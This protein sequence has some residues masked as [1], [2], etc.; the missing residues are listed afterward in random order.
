MEGVYTYNNGFF[1]L[2]SFF[3]SKGE[4]FLRLAKI[5]VAN[6][7]QEYLVGESSGEK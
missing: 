1:T 2:Q 5:K 7:F 4:E 6:T 3:G